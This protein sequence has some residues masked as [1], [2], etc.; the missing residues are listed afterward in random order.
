VQSFQVADCDTDHNLVVAEL[1]ET[2]SLSKR[3]RKN[4]DVERFDLK[5]LDDAEVKYQVD[6]S[7]RFAVLETLDESFG[8]NNAWKSIRQNIRT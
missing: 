7:N 5:K 6:I 3:A 2:I 4:S 1:R 8:I